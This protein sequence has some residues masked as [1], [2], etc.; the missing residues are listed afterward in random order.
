MPS[1]KQ[2]VRAAEIKLEK[3]KRGPGKPKKVIT[4]LTEQQKQFCLLWV[5]NFNLADAW[6][7]AKNKVKSRAVAKAAASRF[8]LTNV[9]A[10]AYCGKLLEKQQGRAE[11]KAD[12]VVREMEALGFSNIQDFVTTDEDGEFCFRSWQNISREKFAAVESVK[13]TSTTTGKGN[14]TYTT[15]NIQFKLYSKI[16]ALENLGKRFNAFPNKT[17]LSGELA[18]RLILGAPKK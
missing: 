2:R 10:Q 8:L 15:T 13:V 4:A 18:F 3:S 17:E 1:T 11:K 16:S 5:A 6:I 7:G 14:D 9:N 12:D